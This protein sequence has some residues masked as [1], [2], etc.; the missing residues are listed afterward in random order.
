MKTSSSELFIV[1]IRKRLSYEKKKKDPDF[2][3]DSLALN[4]CCLFLA[5]SR[6]P[7]ISFEVTLSIYLTTSKREGLYSK[8]LTY[9]LIW[10]LFSSFKAIDFLKFSAMASGSVTYSAFA[11]VFFTSLTCSG[12]M[13]LM[14][15]S[16]IVFVSLF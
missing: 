2:P 15:F 11:T 4:T 16:V 5:A 12:L 10:R 13:M 7:R 6:L 9:S 8:I 3:A 14:L 1:L